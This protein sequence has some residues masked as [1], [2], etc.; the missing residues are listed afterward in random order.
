MGLKSSK[1]TSTL[2]TYSVNILTERARH[3]I[4]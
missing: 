1:N 2:K 3:T 4:K